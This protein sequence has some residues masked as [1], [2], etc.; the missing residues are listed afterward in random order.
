MKSVQEIIANLDGEELC[1]YCAHNSDC[2]GGVHCSP[3][4]PMYPPCADGL[5]EEDFDLD[6]FME[7]LEEEN[8]T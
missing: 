4:G 8:E 7:D 3:N 5:N 6:A 1:K 2:P